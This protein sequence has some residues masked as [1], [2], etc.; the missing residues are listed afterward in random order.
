MLRSASQR[1][2]PI[3]ESGANQIL[4]SEN[5]QQELDPSFSQSHLPGR[6]QISFASFQ[7]IS[8]ENSFALKKD[9]NPDN[10]SVYET[11]IR[12]KFVLNYIRTNRKDP[13]VKNEYLIIDN[14]VP[15]IKDYFHVLFYL[16]HEFPDLQQDFRW[17][18]RRYPMY[19]GNHESFET[20]L[21]KD[22]VFFFECTKMMLEY[23]EDNLLLSMYFRYVKSHQLFIKSVINLFLQYKRHDLLKKILKNLLGDGR[24]DI[25]STQLKRKFIKIITAWIQ[26]PDSEPLESL[27]AELKV[28]PA[29]LI[30]PAITT[31][32]FKIT[33]MLIKAA[34]ANFDDKLFEKFLVK[35][36]Y[37]FFMY[38]NLDVTFKFVV[39]RQRAPQ[40]D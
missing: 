7:F 26:D 14:H 10:L 33:S 35:R 3:E 13:T 30:D 6:G 40:V 28:E 15:I 8:D 37:D 27:F 31:N 12:N 11:L 25:S 21:I 20:F 5:S 17:L 24:F 16:S 19:N 39:N 34:G 29:Q 18:R 23:E 22:K 2:V 4:E 9:I 1:H 38:C 32:I 36:R